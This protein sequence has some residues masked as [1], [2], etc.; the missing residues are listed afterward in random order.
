MGRIKIRSLINKVLN[1]NE[2]RKEAN[3]KIIKDADCNNG[4]YNRLQIYFY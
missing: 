1:E 4:F 2:L 3:L